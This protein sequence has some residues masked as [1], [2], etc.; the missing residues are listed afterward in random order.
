VDADRSTVVGPTSFS[1]RS[2]ASPGFLYG[3][4]SRTCSRFWATVLG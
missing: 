3:R 4:I 2:T 1:T